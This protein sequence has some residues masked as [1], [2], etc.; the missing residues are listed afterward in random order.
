V[1]AA[2]SLWEAVWREGRVRVE[3][4]AVPGWQQDVVALRVSSNLND[5]TTLRFLGP[6][7]PVSP[8]SMTHSIAIVIFTTH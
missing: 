8:L 3:G 7:G 2:A 4:L 5:S 1:G 6:P